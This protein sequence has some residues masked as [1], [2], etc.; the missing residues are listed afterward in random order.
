MVSPAKSESD[1]SA[2]L[3]ALDR[4]AIGYMV[5]P[6]LLF[7]AGWMQWWVAL[8][9]LGCCAFALRPLI[10]RWPARVAKLPVTPLHWG[11]AVGAG[12]VWAILGGVG[13]FFFSNA[14]WHVRDAVLH[15]LVVSSWPVGYGLRDGMESLLRA[16]VAYYLPAALIGKILGVYAAHLALLLWTAAGCSLF[17]TQ[18]LS[19]TPSRPRAV[20]IVT[21]VI[22]LFSG[23]DI[24][25]SLLNDGPRF[26][27]DWNI[28]THLEW[29]AGKYQYSSMTTQ[30][31]WVPNHALGGWITMGLL[32]RNE[33]RVALDA[34]LPIVVVALALWSPLTAVGVVP[35]VLL[36]LGNSVFRQH[37]L[38]A[39]AP[40]VWGPALIVGG[41]VGAFLVLDSGGIPSGLSTSGQIADVAMDLAQ[42]AQFFLL[43]AGLMGAALLWLRRSPQT[44]LALVILALL[45]LANFGPANDLV[46]RASIPSLV[47]LAIGAALA[48]V[49]DDTD[50]RDLRKKMLLGGF[51]V[52]GA[53]TALDEIAR[54]VIVPT[55]PVNLDATLIGADCGGYAPHYVARL[56]DQAIGHLLRHVSRLPIGPQGRQSCD[57]P[58]LDL[59]WNWNLVPLKK[60]HQ[61]S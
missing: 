48:L 39:L 27:S 30:L 37:S 59:M 41:V 47:A 57:N 3:D 25:G 18:V 51:L 5:L 9:L 2:P 16:P 58:G 8:P 55:W 34:L 20:L 35:F 33:R 7:L 6:L 21:A 38:T 17:L 49:K 13:H 28:T 56:K 36:K 42:Q 29:W 44:V 50:S 4:I 60:F 40:G 24:V 46:M 11:V 14:D 43:E 15:D 31:F 1:L 10:A 45:P 54:A 23:L 19:L 22:V 61:H 52:L 32:F 53:T 26:R 12:C